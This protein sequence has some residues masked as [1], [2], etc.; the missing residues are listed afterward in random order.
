MKLSDAKIDTPFILLKGEPGLRKSTQ[1]LSFAKAGP[2]Y[3]FSF[4]R[5][6][7]GILIPAKKWGIDTSIIEYDDYDDWNKAALKLEQLQMNAS[8]YKGGIILDSVTTMADAALR[9]TLKLKIGTS[10]SSG[11]KA[12]KLVGGIAVNEMEDY[13]AEAGAI[14]EMMA[15][16]KDIN[17]FHKIPVILIAHVFESGQKQ[18]STTSLR[19]I[20]TAGKAP[21]AKIPAV[22]TEVIH[23]NLKPGVIA[24]TGSYVMITESN[25]DDFAR[26]SI[27]LPSQME[28][29]DEPLYEKWFKPAMDKMNEAK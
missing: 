12:G 16:L 11:A 23:F 14:N 20:V 26:T 19:K 17:T 13:N 27:A 6:M 28:F 24:G 22:C 10:R 8:K 4:D 7:S 3:W 21:A 1:A 25:G 15:L 18:G 9:Q 29:T 5:K 2:Q